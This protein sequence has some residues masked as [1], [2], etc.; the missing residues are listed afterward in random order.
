M[1]HQI[2]RC[3]APCTGLI[4]LADYGK[5]VDEA[6][7]FLRGKSRAVMARMAEEMQAAADDLEFERAARLRDRIRALSSVAQE[8]QV[9]PE[10]I[11][12][13]DVFA[14]TAEGGQACVQV[15]FFRAGQNW[16]NRAYFPRV[17]KADTDR[18]GDGGLP[19]P[20]LRGQAHPAPD[21]GERAARRVRADRRGL[22][23]EGRPQDRDR[24]SAARREARAGR[25][26][27]G[28]RPRGAGPQDGGKLGSVRGCWP[29]SA[30]PSTWKAA[31]SGSRSTTT[32]TS[33]ARTRSAA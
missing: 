33:W 21:P 28:Q 23:A 22:L 30:R 17:D 7:A 18:R 5:L 26:R 19:R 12:E 6:E 20:V 29:A 1:L 31:R 25:P 11:D 15:F 3:S 2:R 13:A 14:L 4:S 9:N 24:P 16:G 27:A 32:A 10:T 8:T